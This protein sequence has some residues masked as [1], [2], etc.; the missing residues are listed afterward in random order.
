LTH[1]PYIGRDAVI[2]IEG[3]MRQFDGKKV[4]KI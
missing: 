3:D 4:E 1:E 2:V